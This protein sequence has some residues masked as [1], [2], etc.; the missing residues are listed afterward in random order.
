MG[1]TA[2]RY[3]YKR[4]LVRM[5]VSRLWCFIILLAAQIPSNHPSRTN[6]DLHGDLTLA[7]PC[8]QTIADQESGYC[9]LTGLLGNFQ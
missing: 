5:N 8:R 1:G 9:A 7:R 6:R 4:S 2:G 3:K